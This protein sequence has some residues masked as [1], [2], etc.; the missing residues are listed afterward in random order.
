MQALYLP[1]MPEDF[2]VEAMTVMDMEGEY[3]ARGHMRGRF[4]GGYILAICTMYYSQSLL[5]WS[6]F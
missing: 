2:L 4:F 6:I 3:K 1:T 5:P